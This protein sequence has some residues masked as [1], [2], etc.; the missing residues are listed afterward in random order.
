M[1]KRRGQAGVLQA[2]RKGGLTER[3]WGTEET[4]L[5]EGRTDS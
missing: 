2:W 4:P 5:E 3:M 1:G